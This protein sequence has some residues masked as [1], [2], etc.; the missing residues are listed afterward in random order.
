LPLGWEDTLQ[1]PPYVL[2]LLPL[3]GTVLDFELK[4]TEMALGGADEHMREKQA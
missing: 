3:G 2:H 1:V 4:G